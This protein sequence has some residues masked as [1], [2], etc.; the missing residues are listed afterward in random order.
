MFLLGAVGVVALTAC[1]SGPETEEAEESPSPSATAQSISVEEAVANAAKCGQI[2]RYAGRQKYGGSEADRVRAEVLADQAKKAGEF[3]RGQA[4]EAA[5][6]QVPRAN[7]AFEGSCGVPTEEEVTAKLA[8]EKRRADESQRRGADERRR[9]EAADIAD[10][11]RQFEENEANSKQSCV[12]DGGRWVP[13]TM[14]N[15]SNFDWVYGHCEP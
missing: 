12:Q 1:G 9:Q 3:W 15:A 5:R 10:R 14:R 4:Q 2:E 8:E 6:M 7:Q 13:G 11:A